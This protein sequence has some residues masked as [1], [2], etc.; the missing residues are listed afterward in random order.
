MTK[1]IILSECE[2]LAEQ[3]IEF[4]RNLQEEGEEVALLTTY[5]SMMTHNEKLRIVEKAVGNPV[6]VVSQSNIHGLT[7]SWVHAVEKLLLSVFF[8]HGKTS[9]SDEYIIYPL[10]TIQ[11]DLLEQNLANAIV[12]KKDPS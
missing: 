2:D 1:H 11:K 5:S 6:R 7:V 10:T 9:L 8:E 3:D 4:I 12:A